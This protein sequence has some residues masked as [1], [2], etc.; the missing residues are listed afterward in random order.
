[1]S[2][3]L[4][5]DVLVTQPAQY[6]DYKRLSTLAIRAYDAKILVRGGESEHL[7]GRQPGRTVVLEFPTMDGARAFYDS[8]QYRRARNARE[9]A[10]V[11]NMFIVQGM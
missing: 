2:A 10:A 11:M 3:Y 6:E 5:A 4:I 8:W 1:M 7:E 9:G